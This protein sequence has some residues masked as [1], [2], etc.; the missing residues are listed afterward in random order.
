M[1]MSCLLL[2]DQGQAD[3]ISKALSTSFHG[4]L[5]AAAFEV[6]TPR[7]HSA[8]IHYSGQADRGALGSG[9]AVWTAIRFR[10]TQGVLTRGLINQRL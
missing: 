3:M 2:N 8:A 6:P 5:A 7:F 4:P 10:K 1:S 9:K